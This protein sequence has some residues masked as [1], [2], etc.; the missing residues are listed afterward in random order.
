MPGFK[1]R[2]GVCPHLRTGKH[3]S[4]NRRT[5]AGRRRRLAVRTRPTGARTAQT[6]GC[7]PG[8]FGRHPAPIVARCY[9]S[10]DSGGA[11]STG[12]SSSKASPS[13]VRSILAVADLLE[14]RQ[15]LCLGLGGEHRRDGSGSVGSI[16]MPRYRFRPVAAGI[17]FP[18][19]TFSFRPEQTVDLALDRRVREHLRRLLERRR[20]EERLRRQR[21]LRDPE[22]QRLEGRLLPLRLASPPRSPAP[23]A[24]LSTSWPG[25]R[26][27]VAGGLDAHLLQHLAHDQ[28]D[29][30]VV[31]VDAL[32]LV[33]LLHLA[34]EVQLRR[35]RA[36]QRQQLSRVR[37]PLVQ[38]VAR[39]DDLAVSDE[40][41][42]PAREGV[43]LRRNRLAVLVQRVRDDR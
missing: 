35:G 5:H 37:R 32:R 11:S 39:L 24:A 23:A 33:D 8:S 19:I 20:R 41:P 9:S 10:V 31:D 30:L 1:G 29:V 22:D 16:S 25:K 15:Q 28:L 21:R 36:L 4:R 17:S 6:R 7:L 34:D 14:R 42:R 26:V 27:G 38:R 12:S 2:W 13:A 18:M 43:L 40:Q 3:L